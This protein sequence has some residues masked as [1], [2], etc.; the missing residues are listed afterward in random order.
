MCRREGAR[1][2]SSQLAQVKWNGGS[3]SLV[4]TRG[5]GMTPLELPGG[6]HCLVCPGKT[7]AGILI[8]VVR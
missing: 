4:K 5:F 6:L 7:L 3:R 1:A 2:Q 8:L